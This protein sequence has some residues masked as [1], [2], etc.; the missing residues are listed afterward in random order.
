[1]SSSD[2]TVVVGDRYWAILLARAI[3]AALVGLAI[4]FS[5]DHSVRVGWI[6]LAF[7]AL[8]TGILV[9]LGATRM[10]TGTP[11]TRLT[12]QGLVLALGGAVAAAGAATSYPVGTLVL[13]LALIFAL[14][15]VLELIAGLRSR[16]TTPVARDWIFLGAASIVFGLAVLLVP[17]DLSQPIT[18]PGENVPNL[19]ASVVVVGALGAY[20]AIVAVYLVIA[21]LSLKWAKHPEVVMEEGAS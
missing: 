8:S 11:K 18:V 3:P 5:A 1:M 15:G 2:T 12:Q 13:A 17:I 19:T 14:S 16:G 9:T 7:F 10:L 20:A 21:G 4:T 6:A